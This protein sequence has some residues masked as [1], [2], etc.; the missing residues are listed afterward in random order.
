MNI[1][2]VATAEIKNVVYRPDEKG[3]QQK[4]RRVNHTFDP[5]YAEN[6]AKNIPKSMIFKNRQN[7]R[8]HYT[9]YSLVW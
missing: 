3:R 1:T 6:I 8:D 2:K 9:V 5:K 4:F 7:K